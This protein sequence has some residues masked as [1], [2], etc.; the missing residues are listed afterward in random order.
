MSSQN[1]AGGWT[2]RKDNKEHLWGVERSIE[3]AK[4]V[5]I[6]KNEQGNAAV[7]YINNKKTTNVIQ[8]A[9]NPIPGKLKSI[10]G[11]V[12]SISEDASAVKSRIKKQQRYSHA[13]AGL[14][15]GRTIPS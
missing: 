15:A 12:H 9:G 2:Q 10:D 5:D 13:S 7:Y 4:I 11:F 1:P 14:A 6:I 8:R 3:L